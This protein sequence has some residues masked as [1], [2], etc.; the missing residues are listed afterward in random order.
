MRDFK[1]EARGRSA[2]LR[3]LGHLTADNV[4]TTKGRVA[5][6]INTADE[7]LATELMMNGT[8]N[9]LDKHQLVAMVS[10]LVQVEKSNEEIR[11]TGVLATPL[12]ALQDAARRIAE[13]SV[14]CKLEVNVEDYVTSFWPYLMDVIYAWSKGASF[15]EICEMTDLFEG[16]IV[17]AT[18][19]LDELMGELERAALAVGDST[20]A[21][22]IDESRSTIRRDI[23]FAA[24]LYI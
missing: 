14:E 4:V 24:S 5:C 8:F 6:E 11:L 7:L 10:C 20:L 16:S 17:R 12:R 3:R 2:V 1:Q 22:K 13:T 19:R 18:R 21:Q 9:A 23:M 15:A